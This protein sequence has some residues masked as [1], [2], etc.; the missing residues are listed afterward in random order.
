MRGP[1]LPLLSRCIPP[2]GGRL[3]LGIWLVSLLV[4]LLITAAFG[5]ATAQ[6]SSSSAVQVSF[7]AS[8]TE[9][10]VG[11]PVTLTLEITHPRD[12]VVV[13]PRLGRNWGQIEVLSQTGARITVNDSETRTT[14]QQID[15]TLFST[16]VFDTPAIPLTVR[17]PDGSVKQLAT[18]PVRL[19]VK[20]VL[21]GPDEPLRDLREQADL[22]TPL[23]E[24]PLAR[25]MV[26]SAIVTL[27]VGSYFV[28]Y[29]LRGRQE[30][31]IEEETLTPLQDAVLRLDDIESRDLPGA[32]NFKEH[33]ALVSQVV[34]G[35]IRLMCFHD[36]GRANAR[37]MTTEELEA[38]LRESPFDAR[39]GRIVAD[40]LKDAD[41]VKFA[42]HMP[43][44]PEAYDALGRARVIIEE[45]SLLFEE[46]GAT[47]Q[48][49]GGA[50]LA[51]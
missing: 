38:K 6:A 5:I 14:R 49:P 27:C 2:V 37:E 26:L 22:R 1:R 42:N 25:V 51:R 3:G 31:A 20:S 4:P 8:R 43:N 15:V 24:Q 40:L 47:G 23:W 10:T 34:S 13:V 39:I 41:A 48:Y 17:K 19:T 18:P 7:T 11:D 36:D 35:Y 45:A 29:R 30:P 16:G 21:T 12:H 28:Y 46:S 50:G 44:A 33:Y 9:L 32:G